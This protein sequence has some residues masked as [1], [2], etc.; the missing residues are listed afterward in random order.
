MLEMNPDR[1]VLEELRSLLK[2]PIQRLKGNEYFTA[3]RVY[4][5]IISSTVDGYCSY[6]SDKICKAL[7]DQEPDEE[8]NICTVALDAETEHPT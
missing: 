7:D 2:P 5:E 4:R 8:L 6:I 3:H 1:S